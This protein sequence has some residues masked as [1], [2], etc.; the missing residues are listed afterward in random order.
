M[1][2]II[3]EVYLKINYDSKNDLY[4][5]EFEKYLNRSECI[6]KFIKDSF[7]DYLLTKR[8][9]KPFIDCLSYI[10]NHERI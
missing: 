10:F 1:N 4:Y 2:C 3:E 8:K 5:W 6:D 7:V 9:S